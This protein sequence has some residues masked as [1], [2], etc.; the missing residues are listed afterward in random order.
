[1]IFMQKI[2]YL[3]ISSLKEESS[4]L[5]EEKE[6]NRYKIKNK[7]KVIRENNHDKET[8]INNLSNIK[9]LCYYQDI[10][11]IFCYINYSG[12]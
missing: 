1:M 2:N 8:I 6:L 11:S 3:R 9:C 4:S 12:F 10:N 5:K 7:Y